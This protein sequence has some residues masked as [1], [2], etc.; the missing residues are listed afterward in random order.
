VNCAQQANA[1]V[2]GDKKDCENCTRQKLAFDENTNWGF[3]KIS[4][5]QILWVVIS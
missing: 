4:S 3:I 5:L 1:E 2:A